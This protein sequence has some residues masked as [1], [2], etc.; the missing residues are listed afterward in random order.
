MPLFAQRSGLLATEN[1]FTLGPLIR[2]LEEQGHRV[3]KCNLG[4]PDFPLPA[5]VREEVKRQ[6]DLDNTHYS[7]PQG[8]PSLRRAIATHVAETRG[9]AVEPERVVVFPGAKPPIGLCQQTYVE[10]GDEVVYPSPGFPIYESFTRYVGAVPVPVHLREEK[11][12]ALDGEELAPLI[13]PRT[14][15]VYL[16]FP[17]NPTGGVATPEQLAELAAV[18]VHRAS[19]DVRVYSDEVYEDILFDGARHCSIASLPGMERRTVIVSGVSKSY[20]WTGGR[21][22]WAV[23]PTVEEAQVF[24]NLNINYYSSFPPYNQ[25]GARLALESP[26]SRESITG[27]VAAFQERRDRVVTGLNAIPGV[28]C[29]KPRGTFYVFPNVA[30]A[31]RRL[32]AVDAW[33]SMPPGQRER[34]SPSTLLQRFLLL[35]HHVATLDRRS[36]GALGSEGKHYLRVSIATAMPDLEE[37]VAR[38]GRAVEDAEGFRA[39]FAEEIGTPA[40]TAAPAREEVVHVA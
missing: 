23:F 20:A 27:M 31:C 36:F 39:F 12:F 34:S 40:A 2:S 8:L 22:G 32:G 9:I 37:A 5:H 7:D 10:P 13:G 16:N 6:L 28:Q 21:L 18:I 4:E 24:K 33:E 3:I 29:G 26:L 14:K 1:A 11:G 25:E 35:R 15:L 38:I 19:P 17:S 30:A